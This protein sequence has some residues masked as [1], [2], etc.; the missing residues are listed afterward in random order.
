M[1][2]PAPSLTRRAKSPRW[3]PG[4]GPVG[5][6]L[7]MH[8]ITKARQTRSRSEGSTFAFTHICRSM[9]SSAANGG[10]RL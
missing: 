9:Q 2:T 1:H 10:A 7:L 3:C 4:R 8:S 5:A 6:D